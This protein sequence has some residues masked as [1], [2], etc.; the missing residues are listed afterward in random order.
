MKDNGSK[1]SKVKPRISKTGLAISRYD[2]KHASCPKNTV[3]YLF[4]DND[5]IFWRQHDPGDCVCLIN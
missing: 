3:R 5:E 4:A 2:E 1:D